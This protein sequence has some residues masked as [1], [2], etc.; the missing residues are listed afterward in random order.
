[1]SKAWKQAK[2]RELRAAG[3]TQDEIAGV[4]GMSQQTISGWT[5]GI[6]RPSKRTFVPEPTPANPES[7]SGARAPNHTRFRI[8]MGTR[9]MM[10]TDPA[11]L[12]GHAVRFSGVAHVR[13]ARRHVSGRG[14]NVTT[15]VVEPLE[16]RLDGIGDVPFPAERRLSRPSADP[17]DE[18]TESRGE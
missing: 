7:E 5:K 1:V 6:T 9:E 12:V 3:W 17:E 4:L 16:L 8:R 10:A 14:D 15:Y 11:P 13:E 18:V 2:A